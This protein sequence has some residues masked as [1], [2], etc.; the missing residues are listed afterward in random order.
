[1]CQKSSLTSL[2]VKG[3]I[4][5]ALALWLSACGFQLRG[6][7]LVN[8]GRTYSVAGDAQDSQFAAVLR[9]R[10]D[11]MNVLGGSGESPDLTVELLRVRRQ[12][13][14]G[15]VTAEAMLLEQAVRIELDYRVVSATETQSAP[16]QRL[17]RQRYFRLDRSN[18]LGTA[19]MKEE[20]A[21]ELEEAL[22]AQ[23]LRSLNQMQ[24]QMSRPNG[25]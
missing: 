13:V 17:S 3:L 18:L 2:W 6:Q 20:I 11:E 14:D 10:L 25:D 15:A 22:A 5:G 12:Q 8:S 9:R 24:Q 19:A 23:L 7:D 16:V 21:D 4:T 1:M